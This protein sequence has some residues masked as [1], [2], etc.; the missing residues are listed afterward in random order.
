MATF[1]WQDIDLILVDGWNVQPMTVVDITIPNARAGIEKLHPAGEEWGT[2]LSLG[3]RMVDGDVVLR[4]PINDATGGSVDAFI[5]AAHIVDGVVCVGVEGATIGK[6]VYFFKA[7]QM[8]YA[9]E[10]GPE[11]S[12]KLVIN[13]TVNGEV[14]Q[15]KIVTP[16]ATRTADGNSEAASLNNAASSAAGG[17]MVLQVAALALGTHTGLVVTLRHSPDNVTFADHTAFP[18][19]TGTK[20]AEIKA[21]SGTIDQYTAFAWDFTGAGSPTA[22]IFAALKRS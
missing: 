1:G 5:D 18:T 14:Y 12:T 9:Q 10:P 13:W 3:T 6:P 20:G 19:V 16:L 4:M 7:H 15:G 11:V 17:A 8:D 22:G 2:A 21:V